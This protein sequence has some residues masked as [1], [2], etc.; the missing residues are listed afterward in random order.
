MNAPDPERERVSRAR[1]GRQSLQLFILSPFKSALLAALC[2][3]L[4]LLFVSGWIEPSPERAYI[5]GQNEMMALLCW[6][7]GAVF[8]RAAWLGAK[9]QRARGGDRR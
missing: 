8:A 6:A 9:Q 1:P 4:G 3:V 5:P 2:V 7:M